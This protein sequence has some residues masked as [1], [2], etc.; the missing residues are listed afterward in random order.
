VSTSN[1]LPLAASTTLP[2]P[3][4]LFTGDAVYAIAASATSTVSVLQMGA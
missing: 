1:G 3:L 2:Q 4:W